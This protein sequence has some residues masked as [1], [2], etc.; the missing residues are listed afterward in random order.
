MAIYVIWELITLYHLKKYVSPAESEAIISRLDAVKG[1]FYTV[2]KI[3]FIVIAGLA[4]LA[5]SFTSPLFAI[6]VFIFLIVIVK[7]VKKDLTI[8]SLVKIFTILSFYFICSVPFL[9]ILG[10]LFP[11]AL[12]LFF[13]TMVFIKAIIFIFKIPSLSF[14]SLRTRYIVM[15]VMIFVL[16][17]VSYHM[18]VNY[19]AG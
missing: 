11:F 18:S 4:L 17:V 1:S 6:P 5:F 3:L 7:S 2:I 12:V 8:W 9:V 16:M 14:Y 15:Q 19:I 13:G 10:N